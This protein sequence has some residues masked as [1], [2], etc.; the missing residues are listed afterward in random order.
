MAV[1]KRA[2]GYR[3]RRTGTGAFYRVNRRRSMLAKRSHRRF[4]GRHL[5]ASRRRKISLG[6]RRARRMHR[7]RYGRRTY[8]RKR[9]AYGSALHHR[10]ISHALR[11]RRKS[12]AHRMRISHGMRRHWAHPHRHRLHA[13]AIRRGH[14]RRRA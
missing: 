10:R 4:R 11:G 14:R 6:E 9:A 8:Y 3:R 12:H 5:S 7:T 13:A 1:S 2:Q